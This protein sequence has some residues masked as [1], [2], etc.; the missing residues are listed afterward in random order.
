MDERYFGFYR[1]EII[2]KKINE[3]IRTSFIHY[4]NI[5]KMNITEDREKF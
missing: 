4:Y 2:W 5:L 1:Q 3:I